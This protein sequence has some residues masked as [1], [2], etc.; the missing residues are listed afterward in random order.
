M[1]DTSNAQPSTFFTSRKNQALRPVTFPCVTT[2][3][4]QENYD[5]WSSVMEAVWRS[6]RMFEMVV[7]GKRPEPGDSP[8]E[9]EAYDLMY[10]QAVSIYLQVVG[11]EVIVQIIDLKDPHDMWKHLKSEYKRGSS[12]ALVFQLGKVMDI[13]QTV[14]D[15]HSI[16][17]LVKQFES[18]WLSLCKLAGDSTDEYRIELARCFSRDKA[19]RDFLLGMLSRYHK[20]VVNNLVA[21]DDLSY[22]Q[23]K[24]HL[25]DIDFKAPGQNS[26]LLTSKANVESSEPTQGTHSKVKKKIT[27]A[28]CKKH[29]PSQAN[30]HRWQRCR[31]MRAAK[32]KGWSMKGDKPTSNETAN[33]TSTQEE[34]VSKTPFYLDTC[35]TAHM[36]PY[37]DRFETLSICTGLVKSS[38]GQ[39]MT[40]KGKGSIV[41]RCL[42]SDGSTSFF[43]LHDVLYVPDLTCPLV[44]WFKIRSNGYH[45]YDNGTVMRL[46]KGSK[47]LL[48]A[49]FIGSLPIVIETYQQTM[50]NAFLSFEFLHEALCHA[51]PASMTKTGRLVQESDFIPGCPENFH[52][53]TCA[54]AKSH[55]S[56]PKPSLFRAKERGEYIHSDLCGPLPVPSLSQSVYYISFVDDAT[57]YT[58]IQFLKS[59]SDATLAIIGFISELETQYGCKTKSFRS[60]NGGEYINNSLTNFFA[61]KGIVHDLTPP[62]SPESNG[63]AERLNRSIGEAIRAMLLPLKSKRLWAEAANTYV[64]TK[65]RL[66]HGSVNGKTPYEAFHGVKPSILHLQPFGRECYVHIPSAKRPSGSK[67]LQRAEKGIFVGYTK[68]TQHYRIYVHEKRRI[69]VSADVEFKPFIASRFIADTNNP[70]SFPES[71]NSIETPN[72]TTALNIGTYTSGDDNHLS[73][74]PH[75]QE[76]SEASEIPPQLPLGSSHLQPPTTLLSPDKTDTTNTISRPRRNVCPRVFE[77]TITGDWWKRTRSQS[78]SG[79]PEVRDPQNIDESAMINILDLPE[80]KSYSEAKSSTHWDR[81]KGAFED[82]IKSLEENNVWDVVP[83]PK[84]RKVINGKWVCKVKGDAD[85][86]VERFKARYVAKGFSQVQ[87]LDYD[88]TFAPVVRFD[89]LRLLLAITAHRKWRPRQL[90]IKTAFLYGILNEEIYMELPDGYRKDNHVA[91]LNRCIYGLKQSPRK[92]YFRLVDYLIPHGFSTTHF[93]P[94]VL[95]HSTGELFIAVYVDDIILFGEQGDLMDKIISTIKA[96]F[97]VSDMGTLH[98]LLGIQIGYNEAGLM[99]SQTAYIQRILI[100][101]DMQNCNPVSTPIESNHRLREAENENDLV[102]AT[103]YQQIIGSLMY[104]V[105]G[106]RPDLAYTISH[107]SQFCSNPSKSHLGAA[108]RVLRYLKGTIDRKLIYKFGAPLTLSGFCDASYGNCIDTRRSFSGYVFQLGGSCISWKSRKQRTV[109]HSTCEAEYMALSL[110]TKQFIWITRGIKQLLCEEVPSALASD[111]TAAIELAH[112][113]KINDASKHIDIAYH[114][115]RERIEDGSLSLLHVPSEENLADICTKGLAGPRHYHLCTILFGTK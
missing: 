84:G 40:V 96:E 56:K 93:D 68:T 74:L 30:G 113:P 58:S 9:F 42:L 91:R 33:M 24:Q 39:G 63:V 7:E 3:T 22:N 106:T 31:K 79:E 82:E 100:K 90:D 13:P 61:Q 35:A 81:W 78:L 73:N 54:L 53:E 92:W 86:E 60:D 109:A 99:L 71:R 20:S 28:Y 107:L 51:A 57:R 34:Q 14:P 110:A 67:F 101:F 16:S 26:A 11:P 115:T 8:E 6:T 41:L 77:D 87:G 48:E 80:P 62:Y 89:S 5:I 88:E 85:G 69:I 50:Y 112:N 32:K 64:Y 10:H 23:V 75:T 111:N 44:S 36:C 37:P 18:E 27:C 72:R 66:A 95:I 83:R 103:R 97:K 102:N 46:S 70:S 12:F 38:S 43:R 98:W 76:Q 65:N 29:F 114:F 45:M 55:H 108:K 47:I 21:R 15:P 25:F 1:A 4:G 105:S 104:L 59:K 49:K 52:C 2:L 94:C 19:K 17:S